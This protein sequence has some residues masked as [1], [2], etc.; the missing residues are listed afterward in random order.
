MRCAGEVLCP[1]CPRVPAGE[2]QGQFFQSWGPK[3]NSFMCSRGGEGGWHFSSSM[4][5]HGRW[6]GWVSPPALIALTHSHIPKAPLSHSP[7]PLQ[8]PLY[9]SVQLCCPGRTKG[10][11]CCSWC[12]TVPILPLR[13]RFPIYLR[14]QGSG[15]G[16][17]HLSLGPLTMWQMKGEITSLM[18]I[19]SLSWINCISI[20]GLI[21]LKGIEANVF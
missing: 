19:H 5:T 3:A 18:S 20:S 6:G 14:S 15:E 12:E 2:E 4:L 13:V 9:L 16:E 10:L 1:L 21:D 11:L 8:V 7:S 17:D